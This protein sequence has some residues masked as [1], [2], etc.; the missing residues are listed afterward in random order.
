MGA[1]PFEIQDASGNRYNNGVT[2]NGTS[3]GTVKFEVPFNVP[4]TLYYQCTSH[5]AMGGALY[6]YPLSVQPYKY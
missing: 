6:I 4:D 2:N 1:H 3:N 5:P